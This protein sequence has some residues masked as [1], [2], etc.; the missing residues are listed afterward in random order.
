[1]QIKWKYKNKVIDSLGKIPKGVE[2]FVYLIT[3]E[4]GRKYVGKKQILSVR[5]VEVSEAVYRKLKKEGAAVTK[6]KNKAKSRRG[7]IVWRYKKIIEKENN[8]VNYTGSCIP[9]NAEIKKGLKFK[10]EILHFCRTKKQ[11]TYYE[12][13]EQFVRGVLESDLYWNENILNKFFRKD[14]N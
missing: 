11:A 8:W 7:N 6:T 14:L 1:M 5:N 9:L 10:K 4:N 2:H 12:L 13:K 3:D